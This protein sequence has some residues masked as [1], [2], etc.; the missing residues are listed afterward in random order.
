[1]RIANVSQRAVRLHGRH[2]VF[3]D[4]TGGR[5]EV[6]RGST[7]VVGQQPVIQPRQVFEYSSGTQI[8]APGGSMF[9]EF[10]MI[11]AASGREFDIAIP[12]TR[13]GVRQAPILQ[14]PADADKQRAPHVSSHGPKRA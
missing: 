10:H 5:I 11:D 6:P 9:G 7:G 3:I 13:F 8:K 4:D 1:V 12:H 14:P 2:L